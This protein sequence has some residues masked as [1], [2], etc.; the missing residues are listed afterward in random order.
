LA[1]NLQPLWKIKK[2][3]IL[4]PVWTYDIQLWG[5]ASN[6]NIKI[7]QRYQSKVLRQIVN[8]PFYISN[9]NIHKDLGIPFAKEEIA[10]HIK[11]Y[12]DRL[13]THENN[14]ALSLENNNDNV[15]RLKRFLVLD[16]PD[17]F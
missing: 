16:I 8:P 5:T 17:R 7:L 13:R 12:I 6:L 10:K 15:R 3:A 14:L 9:A 1:E 11:K 2:K 4:K